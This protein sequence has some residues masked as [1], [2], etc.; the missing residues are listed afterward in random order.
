MGPHHRLDP[1]GRER[2][3]RHQGAGPAL[4]GDLAGRARRWL[5]GHL[6]GAALR[7]TQIVAYAEAWAAAN[8]KA[9]AETG[10]LWV[11]LGDSVTQ[12][13]G[14]S[15]YDRGYVGLLLQQL[16]RERD[17]AFRVVNL[18]ISGA[19]VDDVLQRQV[20][21][22]A[23]LGQAELVT[24]AAG[25]ND[26][27]QRRW[28]ELRQGLEELSRSL[29]AGAVLATLPRGL[30]EREARLANAVVLDQAGHHGLVVADVWVRTGPPWAG[31]YG[32][33]HFHPSDAGHR[34]WAAAFA[35]ALGL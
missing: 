19:R 3:V 20:P 17:P 14:A 10:P 33:D 1:G 34:D 6:P 4:L 15:A 11:A 5:G 7:R 24:C 27:V 2:A 32:D 13:V 25:A 30:H 18:S 8:Q 31:K 12:G 16:R 22:M 9:L 28:L 23:D 35:E 29:P 21:R 26:L